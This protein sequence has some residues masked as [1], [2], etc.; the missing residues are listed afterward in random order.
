[1]P[2]GCQ[3]ADRLTRLNGEREPASEIRGSNERRFFVKDYSRFRNVLVEKRDQV[4]IITLN[5]PEVRN[6]FNGDLARE[7][8]EAFKE[9]A[10]DD[11]V[12][13]IVL[14]G[15]GSVFSAGGDI[16]AM[17]ASSTQ[18]LTA[19]LGLPMARRHIDTI[20]GVEQPIIAAL[21]GDAIGMGATV[22]LFCDV[23]LASEKARIGDPHVR[24]GLVAGDGAAAIWPLLVGVNKA[25]EM[26]LTGDLISALE[27]ERLGLLNR[28]LPQEEVMPAAM[29]L[30]RRLAQGPSKAI[31]WTKLCINKRLREDINLV[32][33]AS[34][35]LE[36]LSAATEDHREAVLAFL[37]KRAPQFKGR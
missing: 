21:N 17:G 19:P 2:S 13:A 29:E 23:V 14:T 10:Q 3:R 18:P 6:A 22:A 20:L 36:G 7:M 27:A 9:V 5:R 37:E 32:L 28:I 12:N 16:K 11:D 15:A 31:R 34:L 1:L 26:L 30:A 4:A 24:M 8:D 35:A 33:D 25:K